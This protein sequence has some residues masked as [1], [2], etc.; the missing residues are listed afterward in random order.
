MSEEILPI[1]IDSIKI[2]GKFFFKINKKFNVFCK[3]QNGFWKEKNYL[4]IG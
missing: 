4:M 1:D 2:I 3:K